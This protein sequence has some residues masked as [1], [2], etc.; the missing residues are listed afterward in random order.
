MIAE[1]DANSDDGAIFTLR[2]DADYNGSWKSDVEIKVRQY[3]KNGVD[4][5]SLTNMV[6]IFFYFSSVNLLR[7]RGTSALMRVTA[8]GF[9]QVADGAYGLTR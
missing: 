5:G 3:K 9:T 2:C 1:K 6:C 8:V 4:Y 7:C